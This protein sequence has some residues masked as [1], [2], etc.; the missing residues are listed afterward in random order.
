[1]SNFETFVYQVAYN[2]ESLS[3]VRESG[4]RVLDNMKNERP[5]WYEYWPIR[6]FLL[7]TQLDDEK[8]YG[9]FSPRFQEKTGLNASKVIDIIEN[10]YSKNSDF[11]VILFSPQPDMGA[12]FINVFEQGEMFHP[13]HMNIAKDTFKSIGIDAPIESMVMDSRQV[14]FSNYFVAKPA[15]WRKWF[16]ISENIFDMAE[17]R[18]HPMYAALNSGANYREGSQQ[19]VFVVERIASLILTINQ[20]WKSVSA[21]TFSFAWSAYPSFNEN[22]LMAYESDALKMAYR[23]SGYSHYMDAYQAIR[24][25]I[26]KV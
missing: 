19:K 21:D 8:W 22:R 7:S 26:G 11:D 14:V 18:D 5:D 17:C 10:I 6:N 16:E 23:E 13:G 2:E 1:M 3:K 4:F 24:R 15:F 20:E 25:K 9:F 12:Y